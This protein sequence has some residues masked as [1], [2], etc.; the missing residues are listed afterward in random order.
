M[1]NENALNSF[2]NF[3]K[4]AAKV[5][6]PVAAAICYALFALTFIYA[7]VFA[8]AWKSAMAF[9][10]SAAISF[11]AA[12]LAVF[13]TVAAYRLINGIPKEQ[14][15]P[16]EGTVENADKKQLVARFFLKNGGYI[17]LVL[18][19]ICVVAV[20]ALGGIDSENWVKERAAYCAS[21]GYLAE[22]D[23]RLTGFQREYYVLDDENTPEDESELVVI[24]KLRIDAD[25]RT[26]VIR[27]AETDGDRITV[28]TR[29]RYENEYVMT[30][31]NGILA[32]TLTPAPE[33]TRTIDKMLAPMF[34]PSAAEKQFI[35]T[36]P[37]AYKD[38]ITVET[39]AGETIFARE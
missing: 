4:Q 38:S 12:G 26:A 17:P 21:V 5:L 13:A 10:L 7:I 16:Q 9:F 39:V 24:D 19:V 37:P 23:T 29:V 25:G 36:V 11:I 8:A 20:A 28:E 32:V 14:P 30:V 2:R 15:Q 31:E 1:K 18:A 34:A 27:Y 3:V 6:L 35:I 33:L 22:T